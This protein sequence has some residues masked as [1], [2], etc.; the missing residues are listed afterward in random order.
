MQSE[1]M[2]IK[3][4]SN[5]KS[6]LKRR[7]PAVVLILIAALT[8]VSAVAARAADKKNIVNPPTGLPL[9][10][11]ID[12]TA[13]IDPATG[14]PIP[15]PAQWKDPNWKDPDIV[16]PEVSYDSLPLSEVYKDLRDKFKSAFDVLTPNEW[17]DP[18]DPSKTIG[19]F[20]PQSTLI[21]MRLKNVT[22]SEVFN[23]M[24]LV[25]E[26]ENTP[27]RWELIMNGKRPTA[28]LR[29][30]PELVPPGVER[31][32]PQ[33]MIYFVGGLLGHEPGYMTMEQLIKTISEVYEMT[34]GTSRGSISSHLQFHKQAELLIASGTVDEV[35]FVGETIAA[36][37]Q[38]RNMRSVRP[39]PD[40]GYGG[41]T[42]GTPA[43]E[44]SNDQPQG[45]GEKAGGTPKASE[46][47][48]KT[49]KAKAP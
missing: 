3:S 46:S 17:R 28:V 35:H 31:Q 42:G 48:P 44:L 34:Y 20:D 5:M 25:F 2:H 40:S 26:T 32:P 43:N 7:T 23:A 37:Q 16:L 41:S 36:L 19:S 13:A 12:P 9:P 10:A 8:M 24:N 45:G 21:R 11:A 4:A 6:K 39:G 14:L 47:K 1:P 33:R 27:L 30:L 29:V 22:A 18:R 49:E 15:P 38:R